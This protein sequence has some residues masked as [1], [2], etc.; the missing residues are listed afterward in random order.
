MANRKGAEELLSVPHCQTLFHF[1]WIRGEVPFSIT[2]S[3]RQRPY[4]LRV[5]ISTLVCSIF[6]LT[7]FLLSYI[8][9]HSK[10]QL[11]VH[12]DMIIISNNVDPML[13]TPVLGIV[14]AVNAMCAC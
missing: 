1:Y 4:A 9:R 7:V 14:P 12:I 3:Q 8:Y 6:L 11:F 2:S 13:F 5:E 10:L